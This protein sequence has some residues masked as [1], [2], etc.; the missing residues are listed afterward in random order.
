MKKKFLVT[1]ALL[2]SN[3]K[4]HFGHL[5]GAYLPA[6]CFCRAMRLEKHD[7]IYIC[8]SDEYGVAITLSADMENRTPKEH[9]DIYHEMNVNLFKRLN[10]QFDH[11]SRTTWEGHVEPSQRFFTELLENGFIEE[12]VTEQLFSEQDDKFLADRYV[13][14][15]CPKCKAEDARGDECP[16]C[17]ASYEATDLIS[18]RSKLTGAK[19]TRKPTTNW[20]MRF[21]KFKDELKAWL[22]T[23][24][25]KPNVVNFVD[26]YIS[27]LRPRAIT[28]D[29]KWGVKLP[30]K[31]TEG[32]VLYVWFDAPVG[33][34]SATMQ[35][36]LEKG[37]KDGK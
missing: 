20:F 31:N 32:K 33:Y 26:H 17:G 27:D 22:K 36:A 15:I 10:F 6:D 21:D 7:V 25:W 4:I 37:E 16:K 5:A 29:S 23:K 11:F 14:G 18:P 30:L 19:L 13:E 35:W 34:I 9:S 24:D 2:Y 8:G 1:S 28:R 12:K 3:G